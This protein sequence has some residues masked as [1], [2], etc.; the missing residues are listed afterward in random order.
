[1]YYSDGFWEKTEKSA[2]KA[3]AILNFSS[4]EFGLLSRLLFLFCHEPWPDGQA[5]S[6]E[7]YAG[8]EKAL[9][10]WMEVMPDLLM[11]I[12]GARVIDF[13]CGGGEQAVQMA[14]RGAAF[15]VALDIDPER[16]KYAV[17]V[18]AA[19]PAAARILVTDRVPPDF[20]AD[21]ITSQNS[22]E[23]FLDAEQ[24]L[25]KWKGLLVPGG[26]AL[27]TFAPPWYSAWGAHMAYFCSLPW[28]HLVFP[29]K[30]ILNVRSRF[31]S[32][33]A[34]SYEEAGLARMSLAKFERLVR[35]SGF[36]IV[37]SRYDCSWGLNF[38]R[39]VPLVRELFVN[40][41]TAVLKVKQ[42]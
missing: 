20:H 41:V 4:S 34:H 17:N 19:N 3:A 13:G 1:L 2:M 15:V 22:F 18:A 26:K 14:Q 5:P 6:T 30:V 31:R 35:N 25:D 32:D 16:L 36:R 24:I 12:Q 10:R 21:V 7:A 29:E 33:G 40:R 39:S 42:S 27:V 37:E 38:L 11:R 8:L 23:H 9:V 28:V